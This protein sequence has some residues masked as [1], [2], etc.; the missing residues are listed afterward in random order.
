VEEAEEEEEETEPFREEEEEAV[1]GAWEP[2]MLVS[3]PLEE[4]EGWEESVR[5]SVECMALR[6]TEHAKTSATRY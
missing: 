3:L 4:E 6:S 1:G 5:T 2:L